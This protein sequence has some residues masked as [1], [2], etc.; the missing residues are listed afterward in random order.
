MVDEPRQNRYDAKQAPGLSIIIS[1]VCI[2]FHDRRNRAAFCL[3]HLQP[4]HRRY[5]RSHIQIGNAT[6][7]RPFRQYRSPKQ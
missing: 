2:G 3:L 7:A 6:E 1:A 5:R 4:Q